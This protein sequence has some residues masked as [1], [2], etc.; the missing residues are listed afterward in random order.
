MKVWSGSAWAEKPAKVWNGSAWV[1]RP[2]KVWDGSAWVVKPPGSYGPNL[3]AQFFPEG[4]RNNSDVSLGCSFILTQD[5][6][7]NK[8]GYWCFDGSNTGTYLVEVYDDANIGLG[9]PTISQAVDLSA[10]VPGQFSYAS[11]PAVTLSAGKRYHLGHV[12]IGQHWSDDGNVTLSDYV[13]P[14]S[15]MSFYGGTDWSWI[16]L[17]RSGRMYIG[18]DLVQGPP[19]GSLQSPFHVHERG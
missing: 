10:G 13:D 16:A 1:T 17:N 19:A 2:V 18:F 14:S 8:V 7:F 4:N 3:V 5:V 11:M 6:T 12:P 9:T 15:I